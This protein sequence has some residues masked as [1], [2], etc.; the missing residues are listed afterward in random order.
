VN[1]TIRRQVFNSAML[2]GL[3]ATVKQ[4]ALTLLSGMGYRV[5]A[6]GHAAAAAE[7]L[8]VLVPILVVAHAD[9]VKADREA[10]EDGAVA[11]GARVVWLPPEPTAV[12]ALLA[13]TAREVLAAH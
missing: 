8:P 10:L 6:V 13:H 4:A 5:V 12:Q 9:T 3:D 2:V 7:R 1:T 11:V